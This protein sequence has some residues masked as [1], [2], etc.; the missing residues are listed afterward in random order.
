MNFFKSLLS[1]LFYR[2]LPTL[3]GLIDRKLGKVVDNV[4]IL[5][6]DL[7]SFVKHLDTIFNEDLC[8][9]SMY[10]DA[11]KHNSGDAIFA[12]LY[13][14]IMCALNILKSI[15]KAATLGGKP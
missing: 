4:I 11:L 13:L 7:D 15:V 8:Q 9:L 1:I 5:L 14:I 10:V 12:P 3:E 2:I 6:P